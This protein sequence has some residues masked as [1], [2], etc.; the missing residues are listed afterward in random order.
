MALS[1]YP[2]HHF[3]KNEASLVFPAELWQVDQPPEELH[4]QG[5]DSALALLSCLR[6]R[7]LAVVGTRRPQARS[8]RIIGNAMEDLKGTDLIILSGLALGIDAKAHEAALEAGLPTVAIL[9]GGIDRPYPRENIPLME[10]ILASGGLV[11]SEFPM[12]STPRP[13]HFLKRNRLIGA[14]PKAV[15]VVEASFRSGA[16]NTACWAR[17]HHRYCLATPC[18]PGDPALAGNQKLL[19]EDHAI[20]FWNV[21]SLGIAW[22]SLAS[23]GRRKQGTSSTRDDATDEAILALEVEKQTT[24]RGGAQVSSLLD[25]ALAR[26]WAPG[27]FFQ[28]LQKAI[29]EKLVLDEEGI[30]V[31]N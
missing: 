20:T 18:F 27:K 3:R 28:A 26:G 17:D 15:W 7:G 22:L 24:E 13:H 31:R 21:G 5:K 30:L 4:V 25:W 19:D 29:E 8:L 6:E 9:G 16:L 10:R 12:G 14:W 23:K 1:D 11:V 2:I